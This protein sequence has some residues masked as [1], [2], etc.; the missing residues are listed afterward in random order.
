MKL[1]SSENRSVAI[2]FHPI[3]LSFKTHSSS[4]I[5]GLAFQLIDDILDGADSTGKPKHQDLRQGL[6][7]CPVIFAAE[8][9]P[10][11]NAFMDRRLSE[12]EDIIRASEIVQNSNGIRR[13]RELAKHH[14]D[15]AIQ[16][17]G[18]RV[19]RIQQVSSLL[20]SGSETPEWQ[21]SS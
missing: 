8:E 15:A 13:T 19:C 17:V 12:P 11:L 6:A 9:Y 3:P 16:I 1:S 14:C 4:Y 18:F 2:N 10:E 7:T 5:A 21:R 20:I